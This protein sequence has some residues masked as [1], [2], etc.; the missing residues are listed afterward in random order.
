M[1]IPLKQFRIPRTEMERL[2]RAENQDTQKRILD[3]FAKD[4]PIT[5]R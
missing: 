2:A 3:V 4:L 5:N 1:L